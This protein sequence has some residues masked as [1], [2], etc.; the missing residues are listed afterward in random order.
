MRVG[1]SW[2]RLELKP[3]IESLCSLYPT[4]AAPCYIEQRKYARAPAVLRRR[5]ST[6]AT[7]QTRR[8]SDSRHGLL[9]ATQISHESEMKTAS[10]SVLEALLKSLKIES[11]GGMVVE[12]ITLIRCI[13]ELALKLLVELVSNR[14]TAPAAS[15]ADSSGRCRLFWHSDSQDASRSRSRPKG[16]CSDHQ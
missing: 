1:C 10:L 2:P 15:R 7:T 16:D 4:K 14:C 12:A 5:P 13:I 9:L 11:S 8:R 3:G 6:K